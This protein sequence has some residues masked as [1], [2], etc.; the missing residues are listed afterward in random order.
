MIVEERFVPTFPDGFHCSHS[1]P[2]GE[3]CPACG[4]IPGPVEDAYAATVW[5]AEHAASLGG[6]PARLVVAGDSA[7]GNLAA[8][9][10]LLARDR[11]GPEIV[12]QLLLYPVTDCSF[13]TESYRTFAE[14][15][16]LRRAAMYSGAIQGKGPRYC[17]SIEAKVVWFPGR[18]QHPVFVEPEGAVGGDF[19]LAG[20]STSLP[21]E[22]QEAMVRT[23]PGLEEAVITMP[24]YA[25]E[26][27]CID[28]RELGPTLESRRIPG[29][30]F[31]G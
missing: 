16:N 23:I 29:V 3:Y 18:A 17:P 19:Y 7:G 25:I 8:A 30:F 24:G 15:Y 22:V 2:P 31:A 20:L 13:E 1:Y 5:A 6:D 28:P 10:A 14:G 11:G 9:V 27:D 26:Y 12:R 4:E 21:S